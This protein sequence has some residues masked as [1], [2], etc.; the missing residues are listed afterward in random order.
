MKLILLRDVLQVGR[1]GDVIQAKPGHARNYLLPKGLAVPAT[2]ANE[3]WFEQQR[4]KIEAR[5]EKEVEAAGAIAAKL[6]GTKISLAKRAGES[7]TLYGSVTATEIA[8]ALAE[9]GFEVDRRRIDLEGGI[10]TLGEHEVRIALHPEVV[11][12]VKVEVTQEA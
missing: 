3:R 12:L 5:S 4:K 2:T 10:K 8:E 11:A 7:E 1:R 6:D 9:Q